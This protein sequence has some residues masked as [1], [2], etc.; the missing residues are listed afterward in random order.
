MNNSELALIDNEFLAKIKALKV[1]MLEET[2]KVAREKTPERD[3][4]NKQVIKEKGTTGYS[5]IEE[6][7]MR[8]KLDEHFPGWSMEMAA[9]LQ[10]IGNCWILAQITLIIIDEK[11]L[12]FNVIPPLRKFYGVDSV[13]IQYQKDK[14]KSEDSI[15]DI[16]DNAKQAVT[17]A[18]K[19]A[20]NRLTRIG[21][22]VYGKRAE[23][24]E[25]SGSIEDIMEQAPSIMLLR[26][27]LKKHNIKESKAFEILKVKSYDEIK[28]PAQALKDIKTTR[29]MI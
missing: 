17:S 24:G 26:E 28:D 27:F 13:R 15:V 25:G 18:L 10:I 16:G 4:N 2:L 22:D 7:F 23:M 1:D 8:A 19:Y 9:P 29:G 6:T 3:A 5:Y 21:D 14:P 11:L 20:I 12:A